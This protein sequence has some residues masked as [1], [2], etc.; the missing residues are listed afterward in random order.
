[1]TYARTSLLPL[2]AAL[3]VAS[4]AAAQ[5][6][7]AAAWSAP[8]EPFQIIGNV[9][10]VGTTELAVYLVTTKDGHIL[11]DG[12]FDVTTPAI[13][14]SIRTLGFKP[15][16]V[17][18]LLTTQA[19]MDHVGSMAALKEATGARVMVMEG[20]AALVERGG[21][22]DFAFGDTFMFPAVTV[23]RVLHDGELVALGDTTLTALLTPGHTRGCT[24]WTMTVNSG[25]EARKVVFAGS[26]SVNPPVRLVTNPSYPGIAQ[27]YER[28]FRTMRALDADVFLGAHAGFFQLHD[29]AERLRKGQ[30][31]NPFIDPA[32]LRAWVDRM[33]G[34]FQERV[35]AE[36]AQG[37]N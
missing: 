8:F 14:A 28:S 36:T 23:D 25:G 12:G 6:E 34:Q 11:I 4:P 9:H 21:R 29:K 18:V 35:A 19:H 20:D 30:Q 10:Y 1:M 27:D 5:Q 3:L 37:R 22:G 26:L 16:D 13:L 2:L 24:T 7:H 17:K 33:E 32:G 15:E 31:P